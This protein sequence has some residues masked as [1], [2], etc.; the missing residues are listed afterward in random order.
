[1]SSNYGKDVTT[2]VRRLKKD[3]GCDV[4]VTGEN[5]WRVTAPNGVSITTS[6]TPHGPY[7]LK[8]IRADVKRHLGIAL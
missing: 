3:H 2:L 7:A 1:M 8:R 5:H 6:R 4:C